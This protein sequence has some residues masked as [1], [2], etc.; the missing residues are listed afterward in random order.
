MERERSVGEQKIRFD[1][2]ATVTLYGDRIK[3]PGADQC[4]CIGCKNF[5]A[6]RSKVYPEDFLRLLEELGADPLK[7]WEA[8]DY[9]FGRENLKSHLYGGWFLFCGELVDGAEKRPERPGFSYWFTTSFPAATVPHDV[10]VCAVEFIT[11]LPWVL[12][13]MPE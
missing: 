10:K 9:D 13:E 3:V 6:Q 4:D 11:E 2:E 12:S 7:E 1:R 5:A 8:F